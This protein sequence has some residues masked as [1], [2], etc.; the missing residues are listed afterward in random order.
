MNKFK[1]F[2]F[3]I[4]IPF[5]FNALALEIQSLNLRGN[6]ASDTRIEVAVDFKAR[7][8][9]SPHCTEV[10][11]LGALD[12]H[13]YQVSGLTLSNH[14]GFYRLDLDLIHRLVEQILDA[15]DHGGLVLADR[16]NVDDYLKEC[17]FEV[18]Q[19]SFH[20]EHTQVYIR[21]SQNYSYAY[22]FNVR[23]GAVVTYDYSFGLLSGDL[24]FTINT[25]LDL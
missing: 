19:L 23:R 22:E 6:I 2:L 9:L 20:T 16:M 15:I 10:R 25:L 13:F 14:E 7:N 3:F 21:N 5:G 1:F 11:E 17:L 4:L 18:S 24:R 8:V 12:P